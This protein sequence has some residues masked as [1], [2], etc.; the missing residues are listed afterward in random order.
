M[1]YKAPFFA[2]LLSACGVSSGDPEVSADMLVS[3]R[4]YP[5]ESLRFEVLGLNHGSVNPS[6]APDRGMFRYLSGDDGLI[7]QVWH[8]DA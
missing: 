1:R 2:M 5:L 4:A 7:G 6:D 3:A 8:K